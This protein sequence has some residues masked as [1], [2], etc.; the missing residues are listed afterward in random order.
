MCYTSEH[1]ETIVK[2][3]GKLADIPDTSAT[4]LRDISGDFGHARWGE[5]ASRYRPMML[6][7]LRERFP[8]LDPDDIVQ[9][10]LLALVAKL[11]SYRPLPNDTGGGISITI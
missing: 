7:Y 2:R 5:F 8:G 3:R 10:T 1:D 11:P 9:E 4:L 6:A